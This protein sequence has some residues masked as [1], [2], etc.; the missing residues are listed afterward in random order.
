MRAIYSE[1]ADRNPNGRHVI[2]VTLTSGSHGVI[3]ESAESDSNCEGVFP[4]IKDVPTIKI[5]KFDETQKNPGF[6]F[7]LNQIIPK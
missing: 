7:S 4:I 2:T 6:L 3:L 5:H 1:C